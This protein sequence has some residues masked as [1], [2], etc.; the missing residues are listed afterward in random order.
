VVVTN[1]YGSVTSSV[2]ALTVHGSGS[3][4]SNGFGFQLSGVAGQTVLIEASTNLASWTPLLTNS[5]LAGNLY[6]NDP[7]STNIARRFYRARLTP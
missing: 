4:S 2:A 7:D 1:T 5:L 3:F 6:F